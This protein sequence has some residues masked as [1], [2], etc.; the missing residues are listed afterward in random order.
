[1]DAARTILSD[2]FDHVRNGYYNS[3]QMQAFLSVVSLLIPVAVGFGLVRAMWPQELRSGLV[4]A[5]LMLGTGC[6]A[7]SILLLAWLLVAGKPSVWVLLIETS[8]A[9]ACMLLAWRG[10]W[11]TSDA[12]PGSLRFLWWGA[13]LMFVLVGAVAVVRLV[14][15]PYGDWDAWETWNMRARMIYLGG[16]HWRDAF[17][18]LLTDGGSDYPLLLPLTIT[19]MWLGIRSA[20]TVAPGVLGVAF[21]CS[22]ILLLGSGLAY[23]RDKSQGL[24]AAM[25]LAA[26]P[27]LMVAATMQYADVE[28]AFFILAAGVCVSLYERYADSKL[29]ALAGLNAGFAGWTKNEGLIFLAILPLVVLVVVRR[30]RELQWYFLGAASPV[31]ALVYHRVRLIGAADPMVAGQG[32]ATLGPRL[33]D[34]SRYRIVALAFGHQFLHFGDSLGA[35]PLGVVVVLLVYA[36]IVGV[37]AAKD[38]AVVSLT[39]LVMLAVYFTV[40]VATPLDLRFQLLTSL[41]RLL[42]QLW[43]AALFVYFLA[44]RTQSEFIAGSAGEWRRRLARTGALAIILMGL[45]VTAGNLTGWLREGSSVAM[46]L[47]AYERRLSSIATLLP[48]DGT[49]GYVSVSL[50]SKEWLWTQYLLAPLIIKASPEPELVILDRGPSESQGDG[51]YTVEEHDG[52]KLYDFG[53]GIYLE[54]RRGMHQEDAQQPAPQSR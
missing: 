41:D 10:R 35:W 38:K 51:A 17:S 23:L 5:G 3:S 48:R 21:A 28:V 14:K 24:M 4:Q 15:S 25:V 16:G 22:T 42:L 1:V 8:V 2:R 40:Y 53:T 18:P 11:P 43:P 37:R 46:E 30:W 52:M 20:A 33:L 19:G 54:D 27:A 26:T 36:V 31:A 49:I 6:G 50:R 32:P 47:E 45:W 13:A 34:L 7:C 12:L 44:V 29:L 39:L 9:T